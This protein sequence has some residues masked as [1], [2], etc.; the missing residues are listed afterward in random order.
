MDTNFD[1]FDIDLYSFDA[2]IRS[3]LLRNSDDRMLKFFDFVLDD[4]V[5]LLDF[6]ELTNDE[7]M[8]MKETMIN[9]YSIVFNNFSE[10]NK[11]LYREEYD[12]NIDYF[13]N[14]L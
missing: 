10:R 12:F 14:K 2:L 5:I 7:I 1:D 6:S 4:G 3:K 8:K 13:K 11:I 9:I